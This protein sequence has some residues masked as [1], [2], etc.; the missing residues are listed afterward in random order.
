MKRFFSTVVKKGFGSGV[1][2]NGLAR[3]YPASTPLSMDAL[4]PNNMFRSCFRK[5]ST[6]GADVSGIS[7][8]KESSQEAGIRKNGETDEEAVDYVM[9]LISGEYDDASKTKGLVKE[10]IFLSYC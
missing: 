8:S 1:A 2:K 4:G 5:K 7:V 3:A 9:K 10:V 6:Y